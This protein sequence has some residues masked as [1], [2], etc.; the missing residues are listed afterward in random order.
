[1]RSRSFQSAS[2]ARTKSTAF[3]GIALG[4][5]DSYTKRF[6]SCATMLRIRYQ[7]PTD[8]SSTTKHSAPARSVEKLCPPRLLRVLLARFE[9]LNDHSLRSLDGARVTAP[10][11]SSGAVTA[12]SKLRT[13]GPGAAK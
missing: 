7:K 5:T 10:E 2:G 9:P 6:L 12:S 11:P 4:V 13:G 3:T 1:M 8:G